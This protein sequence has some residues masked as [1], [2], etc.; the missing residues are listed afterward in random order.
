MSLRRMGRRLPC[1]RAGE[2]GVSFGWVTWPGAAMLVPGVLAQ[3]LST[4]ASCGVPLC[5][6]THCSRDGMGDGVRCWLLI[7]GGPAGWDRSPRLPFPWE[8]EMTSS[9]SST[10]SVLS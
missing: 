5:A 9:S 3:V 8:E 6:R 4:P 1:L 10:P 2:E 7:P